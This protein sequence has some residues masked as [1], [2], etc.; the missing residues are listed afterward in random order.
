MNEVYQKISDYID[1]HHDEMVETLKHLVN[2]EGHYT[3]KERVEAAMD[4][5]RGLLAEEGFTFKHQEVA[6]N[7]AG[8][9]TADLGMD[10]PGKPLLFSG[11][12][13]T[14]FR[15]GSWGVDQ[16]FHTDGEKM[17]GPGVIDMKGGDVIALYA[18]KALNHIGFDERPIR[19]VMV[20]DEEDDHVHSD[21]DVAVIENSRGCLCAFNMEFGDMQN[22]LVIGR[23]TQHTFH[24]TVHGVGGHAGNDVLTGRNALLESAYKIIE[25]SKLA[26]LEIGTSVTPSVIDSGSNSSSIPSLCKFSVDVRLP[27]M[28]EKDRVYAAV[29][30]IIK[31]SH[32]PDTTAEYTVDVAKF[33]PYNET[34]DIAKLFDFINETALE[35]GLPAFGK[36][37]RGGVADSG[38]I[39]AAGVPVLDGCGLVGEYAHNTKEYGLCDVFFNRTKLFAYAATKLTGLFPD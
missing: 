36:V 13:D 26:N 31:T 2:L 18:I 21:G 39:A 16:P 6:P 11:H 14:V 37:H 25:F 5:Y 7:R 20:G 1:V 30:Q 24:V 3:E 32:V 19:V 27:S 17:Y 23:K 34:P 35:I 15:A 33:M 4:Y 29:E 22:R 8:V 10:R 9:I 38:N 28:E 12:F